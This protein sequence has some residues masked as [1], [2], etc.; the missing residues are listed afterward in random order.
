MSDEKPNTIAGAMARALKPVPL[1]EQTPPVE[2]KR[3]DRPKVPAMPWYNFDTKAA[4][5]SFVGR[6]SPE[7]TEMKPV[8]LAHIGAAFARSI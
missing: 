2:V 8:G 6:F 5:D 1:P 7:A 4:A 3:R